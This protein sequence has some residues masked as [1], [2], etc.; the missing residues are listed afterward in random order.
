AMTP[1]AGG[2]GFTESLSGPNRLRQRVD[3][4]GTLGRE[5]GL[6]VAR[7]WRHITNSDTM[8]CF[9][10]RHTHPRTSWLFHCGTC[11]SAFNAPTLSPACHKGLLDDGSRRW[12]GG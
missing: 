6:F 3:R 9:V 10:R 2:L 8:F 4:C 12:S 7:M 5:V 11:I 1:W